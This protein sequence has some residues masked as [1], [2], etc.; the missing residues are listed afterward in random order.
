[1]SEYYLVANQ[2]KIEEEIFRIRNSEEFTEKALDIFR[3]QAEKIS[4][5]KDFIAY[6]KVSPSSI[7]TL[8]EIPFLPVELF[9]SHTIIH[10]D[11]LPHLTFESSGT[12]GTKISRHHIASS[13]IYDKSLLACFE[14]FYGNPGDYCIL[15][16]L[17]SYQERNSSSLI[18]MVKLLIEKTK[19]K[20]SGFYQHNYEQLIKN[21]SQL[22]KGKKKVILIG[23]SFALLEMAEKYKTDLSGII[24]METG[25][26][27]GRRKEIVREE[28][29]QVIKKSFNVENVHSEYGMTELLSQAY[30]TGDGIFHTPPWM[31][32]SIRD[33]YDPKT[34]LKDGNTG[35]VNVIDLANIYSC[36]FVATSDLGRLIPGNGF[37]IQG[38]KDNSDIR[39]CNLLVL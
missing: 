34:S 23:V 30:S 7:R 1:M 3:M 39:G 12:S 15:A 8:E 26:M 36:S 16:L 28:L 37:E 25:G 11:Y 6:L 18:Y 9:K 27:K 17:P 38:R 10:D 2:M 19:C 14:Y 20:H 32:I 29:H 21:A 33:P 31:K 22:V 35:T 13:G 4:I 24:I 5:Y